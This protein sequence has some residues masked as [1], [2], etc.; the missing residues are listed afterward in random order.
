MHYN[1]GQ[2]TDMARVNLTEKQ[3]A[4]TPLLL[5]VES[6]GLTDEQFFRLCCDNDDLRFELTAR[7]EL[8]IMS[9][10]GAKTSWRNNLICT[11]LTNWAEK[12][13]TGLVFESSAEYSLPNGAKRAPDASWIR[14]DRWEALTEEEQEKFPRICPDFVVELMS[15]TSTLKDQQAKME[16]YIANGARLGWLIDPFNK[17]VYVY[18]TDVKVECLE[19]PETLTGEAVLAGFAFHVAEIW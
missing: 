9:P 15:P 5:N 4:A 11:H 8:V 19:Q 7:K 1:R 18:R 2:E 12:D 14:K 17:R 13:A 3:L 16:E 10:A 6:V